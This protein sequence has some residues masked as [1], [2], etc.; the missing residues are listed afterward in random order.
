MARTIFVYTLL[1]ALNGSVARAVPKEALEGAQQAVS[2]KLDGLVR[3]TLDEFFKE[4]GQDAPEHVDVGT[5]VEFDSTKPEPV[6]NQVKLAVTLTSDLPPEVVR[7]ARQELV[8]SIKASGYR[9]DVSEQGDTPVV[10]FSIESLPID[11]SKEHTS[12]KE[13]M[14]FAALVAGTLFF[15]V[16]A[17]QIILWG[18]RPIRRGPTKR[19]TKSSRVP[20]APMAAASAANGLP[21][22]PVNY[23]AMEPTQ[24]LPPLPQHG[25]IPGP[26]RN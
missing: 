10:N 17:I 8:R 23:W 25:V 3:S 21:M 16:L 4:V 15:S 22:V 18:V 20:E 14:I 12:A 6:I 7:Q 13:I 19:R 26:D 9:T 1:L 11:H 2:S 24:D 5:A